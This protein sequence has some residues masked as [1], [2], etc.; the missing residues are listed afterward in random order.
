VFLT[1]AKAHFTF[2]DGTKDD[3]AAKAGDAQ[4]GASMTHL[5]ENTGDSGMDA[6]VVELKSKAE[7]K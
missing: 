3:I 1:D 6:L 4:D 7:K 5:P 2:A